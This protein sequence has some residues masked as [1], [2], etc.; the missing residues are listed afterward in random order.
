MNRFS[1]GL[2]AALV[3]SVSIQG[4][5]R[6]QS[7]EVRVP[8][9]DIM[10]KGGWQLLFHDGCRYAVPLSWQFDIDESFARAPDGSSISIEKL[11]VRSWSA[12]KA[13]VRRS[14]GQGSVLHDNS[15]RRLWIE[16]RDGSRVIHHIAVLTAPGGESTVCT[17]VVDLAA[18]ST[19]QTDD[20]MQRIAD[21]I[22]AASSLPRPSR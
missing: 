9:T 6:V 20:T 21:S 1:A 5:R 3:L 4:Q 12:H 19:A 14:Y 7:D 13:D 2:A 8:G 17:G 11:D 22:G 16:F 15:D 18:H 10:L